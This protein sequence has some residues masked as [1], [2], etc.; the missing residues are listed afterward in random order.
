MERKDYI[1]ALDLGSSG[2]KLALGSVGDDSRL[3]VK[4]VVCKPVTDGVSRGEI[5]NRK[6]V[7][8]TL[9]EAV[10]ELE[11]R[12]SIRISDVHTGISDRHVKCANHEYY[13]YVGQQSNGEIRRE[14]VISLNDSMNNLQ[15]EDG[16]RILERIP[17]F[18]LV[19]GRDQVKD[20]V[21]RFGKKLASTFTFVLGS[22]TMIDRYKLSISAIG[23]QVASLTAAPMFAAEAVTTEE[24]RQIGVLVLDIGQGT[25]DLCICKDGIVR[26]IRTIP[27]GSG[28]INH[29]IHQFGIPDSFVEKMKIT[30]GEALPE[31]I[32]PANDMM[33]A[34]TKAKNAPKITYSTLSKIIACRLKDI[35]GFVAQE[36]KDSGYQGKLAAGVVITGGCSK[37]KNIDKLFARELSMEVRTATAEDNVTAESATFASDAANSTVIGMLLHAQKG[38]T[39]CRVEAIP[40]INIPV[41]PPQ[42]VASEPVQSSF[43]P[44]TSGIKTSYRQPEATAPQTP[45]E[46]PAKATEKQPRTINEAAA[47]NNYGTRNEVI[48]KIMDKINHPEPPEELEDEPEDKP[49]KRS[50]IK[51]AFDWMFPEEVD[52]DDVSEQ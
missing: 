29:D 19:D 36:I 8:D 24:E 48:G 34:C 28:D 46:E 50:F 21:G 9:K 40:S 4:D 15:A 32:T 17:Q 13:V 6:L 51:K 10:E 41:T 20:P 39:F 16:V 26:Y 27:L 14:D 30:H 7:S 44:R 25:T 31:V 42:R 1:V 52:D 37:L 23:L 3:T 5:N 38:K 49:H 11:T 18:Y 22:S 45:K 43:E 47:E 12:N 2:V 33:I 35:T